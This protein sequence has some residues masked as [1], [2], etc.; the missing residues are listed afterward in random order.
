MHPLE[1]RLNDLKEA[2]ALEEKDTPFAQDLKL[3]IAQ[4]EKNLKNINDKGYKMVKV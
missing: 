1:K 4:C 2:L 3:T